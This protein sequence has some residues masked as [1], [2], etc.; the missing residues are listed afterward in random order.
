METKSFYV[1]GYYDPITNDLFYVGKGS[2]YRITS[3]LKPSAWADP[4]NTVNP[5]FYY[6]IKSLMEN[7]S[8]P[9][10]KKLYE[11][12]TEEE[13]YL[14]EHDIIVENGRRF[15]DGGLLFNITDKS[16][17]S[18]KGSS[19]PWSDERREAY[20]EKC[21][22]NRVANNKE[23]LTE[24]FLNLCMS[25]KEIA[26][27]Y[28]VSEVLIKK[29]LKEYGIRK[30]KEQEKITRDRSY[31]ESRKN[32][33]CFHCGDVFMVTSSSKRMFCSRECSSRSRSVEVV[34]RGIRYK[35]K[36]E[37]AEKTGLS[38]IY[39]SNYKDKI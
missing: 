33:E 15:V 14:M 4:K 28:G 38:V 39:I 22:E 32:I 18:K 3:H 34:F 2:G 23:E 7:G 11:N 20:R 29:R 24:M 5:F 21:F 13:A 25:R 27:Y 17:G 35:N 37:A 6:K 8:P 10:L 30:N 26:E 16:G 12:L 1:Y 19:K 36:Y 9:I 31:A